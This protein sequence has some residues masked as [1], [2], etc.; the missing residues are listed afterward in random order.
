[1]Y[2]GDGYIV[3]MAKKVFRLRI[4]LDMRYPGIVR[5]CA[6]AMAAVMPRN[7]VDVRQTRPG[8]NCMQVGTYSRS[9]PCLFPQHGPGMKHTRR[10][11][12]ADWQQHLIDEDPRPLIRG[13][14]HSDGCR[15]I[16][17]SMGHEYLRYMF[18]NASADIRE[19]FTDAC[20]Q[21]SIPWRQSAYRTISVARREGIEILDSFV[22]AKS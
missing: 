16:N 20:D 9:L 4:Y 17:K 21:L 11:V 19:I 18:V 22:G 10:I 1:M 12:L 7:R 6:D 3:A 5:E 15:V 2:L 14:I 13:L 8:H